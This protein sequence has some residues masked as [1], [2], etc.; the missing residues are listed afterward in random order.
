MSAKTNNIRIGLF[1]LV[2][3]ALFIAGLLA[4]GAKGFFVKKLTYETATA[5]PETSP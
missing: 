2:A 1:V 5:R 4:F 3:V